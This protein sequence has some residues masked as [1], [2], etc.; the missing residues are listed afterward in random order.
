MTI[1]R[2]PISSANRRSRES[3]S[4]DLAERRDAHRAE[5]S[6]LRIGVIVGERP[7]FRIIVK[8]EN[9]EA[10]LRSGLIFFEERSGNRNALAKL[11]QLFQMGRTRRRAQIS[12]SFLI[13][14]QDRV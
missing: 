1:L 6:G 13:E 3:P 14:T 8:F 4:E 12:C 10:A 9:E 2:A 7:R 5:Q 11:L